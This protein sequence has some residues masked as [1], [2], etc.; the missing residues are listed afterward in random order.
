MSLTY[1]FIFGDRT[2]TEHNLEEN[3]QLDDDPYRD[4]YSIVKS[5]SNLVGVKL[6]DIRPTEKWPYDTPAGYVF[7]DGTCKSGTG[8]PFDIVIT[9]PRIRHSFKSIKLVLTL[10][11]PDVTIDEFYCVS[12]E[13]ILF[14]MFVDH[15]TIYRTFSERFSVCNSNNNTEFILNFKDPVPSGVLIKSIHYDIDFAQI[16]DGPCDLEIEPGFF[17]R[18]GGVLGIP[19]YC[20][21]NNPCKKRYVAKRNITL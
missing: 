3:K 12:N 18:K 11:N 16:D 1:N 10:S 6:Q 5:V 21:E 8:R 4:A 9:V 13:D 7:D 20:W 14:D 19:S 17:V 2:I 15:T